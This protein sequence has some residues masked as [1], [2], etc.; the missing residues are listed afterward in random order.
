M[1]RFL[2]LKSSVP[3]GQL[4]TPKYGDATSASNRLNN[5]VHALWVGYDQVFMVEGRYHKTAF[6]TS[7]GNLCICSDVVRVD[8]CW[9]HIPKG[10]GE[11]LPRFDWQ[12]NGVLPR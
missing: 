3:K 4:P 12:D 7:L 9:R 11:N 6:I 5:D 8:E 10:H 2:L 1:C